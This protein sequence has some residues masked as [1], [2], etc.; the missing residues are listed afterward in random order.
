MP[1]MLFDRF[2]KF[3]YAEHTRLKWNMS[4]IH[5]PYKQFF[6][7]IFRNQPVSIFKECNESITIIIQLNL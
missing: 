7:E 1:I 5:C 6:T 4:S 3:L 2:Y